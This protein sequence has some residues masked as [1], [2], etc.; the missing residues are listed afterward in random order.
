M[1]IEKLDPLLTK[2]SAIFPA[3]FVVRFPNRPSEFFSRENG[4]VE[5]HELYSALTAFQ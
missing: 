3:V 4:F 5:H 2:R 1:L